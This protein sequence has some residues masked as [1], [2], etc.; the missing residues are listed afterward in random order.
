MLAI[1]ERGLKS[2]K[3]SQKEADFLVDM[4]TGYKDWGARMLVSEKQWNWLMAIG[5]KA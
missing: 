2:S 1:C 5:D 3:V 4:A